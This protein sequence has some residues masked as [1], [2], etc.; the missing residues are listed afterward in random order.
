MFLEIRHAPAFL[1]ADHYY[2]RTRR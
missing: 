2:R 1:G